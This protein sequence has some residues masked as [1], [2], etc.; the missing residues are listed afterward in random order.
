ME[1]FR[2]KSIRL[3]AES[4]LGYGTYFLTMCFEG[5]ESFGADKQTAQWLIEVLRE[6]AAKESFLVHAYCVMPDH[7]HVLA[8]GADERCDLRAFVS[9]FKQQTG[10][11]F[12]KG[13]G[14]RLWQSKY[15]DHILR[16]GGDA[17]GVAWYIW[18][19]PVRKGIC[20]VAGEYPYLGAMTREGQKMLGRIAAVKWVPPW[21]GKGQRKM[22]G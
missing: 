7:M 9:S 3:G 22:P 18:E 1:E 8:E 19:N 10:Y 5:R 14:K 21:K 12:Q 11:V 4:Y 17:E 6:Q 2:R 13:K 16:K 20:G 15:Y